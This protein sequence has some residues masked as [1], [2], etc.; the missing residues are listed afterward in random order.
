MQFEID[1]FPGLF[2]RVTQLGLLVIGCQFFQ[3]AD[4]VQALRPPVFRVYAPGHGWIAHD[5]WMLWRQVAATA[6][7]SD[8]MEIADG[9]ARVA[10]ELEAVEHRTLELC[11]AYATQLRALVVRNEIEPYKRFEDLNSGPVLH[12][13]HA[14]FCEL[15]VLRDYLAEFISRH[16]FAIYKDK[17]QPVRSM[18]RPAAVLRAQPGDD[19]LAND[20]LASTDRENPERGWLATLSACRNLFTHIAP[21]SQIGTRMFTVQEQL[22]LE[23]GGSLPVIYHPLPPDPIGQE[24]TRSQLPVRP[25]HRL[26]DGV[27][28]PPAAS[29]ART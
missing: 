1:T 2:V 27:C 3:D 14:L 7:R 13:V 10:F 15:A 8:R 18:A 16:V 9:A 19:P 6:L 20:L 22:A 5:A 24:K 11:K 12:S 4:E 23:G 26:G 21:V 29:R 25:L 17:T 28:T